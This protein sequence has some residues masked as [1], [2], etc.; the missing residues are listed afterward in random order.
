MKTTTEPA[1]RIGQ[2]CAQL[3]ISSHHLR[4]LCKMGLVEAELS[5]GRQWRVPLNE[6]QRLKTNGVPP[7]PTAID[8]PPHDPGPP[9]ITLAAR[10]DS[11]LSPPSA[12]VIDAEEEA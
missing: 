11:R 2:A 12:D 4:Q 8:E 1:L 6:I 10:N 3:G 5:P 7:C 9:A